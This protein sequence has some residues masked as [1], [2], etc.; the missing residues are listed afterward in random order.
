MESLLGGEGVGEGE[1]ME[2][3]L[4]ARVGVLMLA[5]VVFRVWLVEAGGAGEAGGG[6]GE[7]F[8]F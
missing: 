1:G 2:E 3:A 4:G 8:S 5:S 7:G 6:G